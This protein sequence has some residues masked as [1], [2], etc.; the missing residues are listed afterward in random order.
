[1]GPN[2]TIKLVLVSS[3]ARNGEETV[4]HI[5]YF[6]HSFQTIHP[7]FDVHQKTLT[8]LIEKRW[9]RPYDIPFLS[10]NQPSGLTEILF[11][12]RLYVPISLY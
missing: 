1:M 9:P 12:F 8:F 4:N 5:D 11:H 3:E 7:T 2:T 10:G 6:A